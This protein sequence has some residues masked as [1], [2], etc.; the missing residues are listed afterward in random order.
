MTY[1]FYFLTEE[2][3]STGLELLRK[4]DFPWL[5]DSPKLLISL[6][7]GH[8]ADFLIRELVMSGISGA[9]YKLVREAR[10]EIS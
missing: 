10:K 3:F 6:C 2:A 4:S 8:E 1:D 5:Y 9:S 7:E